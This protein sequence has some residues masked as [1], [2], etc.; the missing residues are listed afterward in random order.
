MQIVNTGPATTGHRMQGTG[1]ACSDLGLS[2]Q[3]LLRLLLGFLA[4]EVGLEPLHRLALRRVEELFLL[5]RCMGHKTQ[6]YQ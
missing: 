6:L 1:N 2:S 5:V 4:L 3:L